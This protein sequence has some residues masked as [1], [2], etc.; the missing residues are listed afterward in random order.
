MILFENPVMQ[1]E[2][3]TN[4]RTHRS[5]ILMLLYQAALAIVVLIAYPQ[6]TRLDLVDESSAARRL[7]D[8]F[9][10]G[11]YILASLMAPSFAAGAI[12]GEKER[13]TYEMLL[14]S[15]LRPIAIVFGKMVASLTHLVM[16]IIGSLP[17][18]MLCLPLGGVSIYE[19]FA[20]YIGLM[21]SAILFGA[22]G[23]AC[24]SYF[25][26]TA[27]SLVVS[28]LVILPLVM[29]AVGLW[30]GLANLGQ[31]RLI[32]A[33]TLFPAV[34]MAAALALCF[35]TARRLLYPPDVGSGGGE[36]IDLER[37]QEKSVGLIINREQFPD[38]L[39]APPRRPGLMGENVNPIYDKEMHAE[40]FSQGTLMLR[41]VIQ[42]SMILAVPLMAWLLFIRAE[43]T[44]YYMIYVIIFNV[45]VAPVF[46]AGSITNERERQTL[47]LLLTTVITPWQIFW[48][49]LLAGFRVSF[50][51]T[52]FL[53][54]PFLLAMILNSIA[55]VNNYFSKWPSL[56]AFVG[57]VMMCCVTNS[58]VAMFCSS[59]ARKTS[60]AMMVSY[61][62]LLGLYAL[63]LTLWGIADA[64]SL[65]KGFIDATRWSAL[66]S[67]MVACISVPFDLAGK[68]SPMVDELMRDWMQ[69]F[70]YYVTTFLLTT[71]LIGLMLALFRNRWTLS[72]REA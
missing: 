71:G 27:A 40:L 52:M 47:D 19:V 39:F 23:L 1:R 59:I 33:V 53:M 2:L 3:I 12:S 45:L 5:F 28:Y 17:T 9:F 32:L 25:R 16:L 51:L 66:S 4:L 69:V 30:L 57:I 8:F 11:Q 26:R 46:S 68:S 35:N 64:F 24:S 61:A 31:L 63:P 15:P 58:V 70:G 7:V 44:G 20:A 10:V 72:W 49:K 43:Y 55:D 36:V 56:L 50:V 18:V 6:E 29:V 22:I 21:V 34:A 67:P 60:V 54:W 62:I 37:E 42:I 65:D 13:K 14:A 41:L 38:R 48:G